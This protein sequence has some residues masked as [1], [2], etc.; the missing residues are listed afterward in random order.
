MSDSD[1]DRL[2]A[3]P[4]FAGVDDEHLA[5]IAEAASPFEV[6][7]GHV[8]AEHGQP[9]SG[10]FVIVEGTVEVDV[11]G[12]SRVT[13]GPGEF[14]GELSLLADSER[15]ARVRAATPVRGLAIDRAAFLGLLEDE[16]RIALAMLPVLARRL[17]SLEARS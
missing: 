8:L 16:P 12:G 13:L 5:R 2:R 7:A 3:I 4:M 10:M 11:P 17:V 15:S 9:G 6:G 14:F 1:A